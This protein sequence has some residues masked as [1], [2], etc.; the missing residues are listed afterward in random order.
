MK[1]LQLILAADNL[2]ITNRKI[3]AALAA[4]DPEPIREMVRRCEAA[5][6]EA[7]DIN[8]GPLGKK[9]EEKM[10][11]MVN[12]VQEVT[13]LP[14]LLDTADPTAM[15]AGLSANRKTAVINGFSLE[16][17]KLEKIL[18]LARDYDTDIVGYLLDSKS[19]V[20]RDS[21]QRLSIALDIYKQVQ[22]AGIAP[23]RLILDPVVVPLTWEDGT[24]RAAEVA[25]TLRQLPDV[26]GF[27]VRTIAG[28]SNLTTGR[29]NARQK[30]VFEAAYLAMLADAG[31]SIALLDMFHT[32]TVEIAKACRIIKDGRVFAWE[33]L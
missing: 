32:Q 23:E 17:A 26:L 28:I 15:K 8:T 30:R 9:A 7:I 10:A 16:P 1:G 24:C 13:D 6:A 22:I 29:G 3:Q 11:F 18:P 33:M 4:M 25:A 27:P 12:T 20:P 31:L 21:A 19:R 2:T 14:V 5:G